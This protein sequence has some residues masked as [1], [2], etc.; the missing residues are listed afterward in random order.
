MA[1][2]PCTSPFTS[3]PEP[4]SS[5]NAFSSCMFSYDE[6]TFLYS[7]HTSCALET[8]RRSYTGDFLQ[9]AAVRRPAL[10]VRPSGLSLE[11]F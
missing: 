4:S 9:G 1:S 2:K 3:E 10:R 6:S 8:E 5:S 7:R 11:A